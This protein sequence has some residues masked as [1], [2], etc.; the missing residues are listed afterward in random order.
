MFEFVWLFARL[1]M[2]EVIKVIGFSLLANCNLFYHFMFVSCLR[3]F[4]CFFFL[5]GL[6]VEDMG[7]FDEDNEEGE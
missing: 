3:F 7:L 6:L 1:I 5:L 4:Y 2:F